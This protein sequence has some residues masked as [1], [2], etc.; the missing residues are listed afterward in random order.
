MGGDPTIGGGPR[1]IIPQNTGNAEGVN[2]NGNDPQIAH[3]DADYDNLVGFLEDA[4]PFMGG[5]DDRGANVAHGNAN[6][7]PGIGEWLSDRGKDIGN[8]FKGI[9]KGIA[10]A[11]KSVRMSVDADYRQLQ[12]DK[13]DARQQ[14]AQLQPQIAQKPDSQQR[15]AMFLTAVG[16]LAS[17]L[18]L[19]YNKVPEDRR[20][21]I[22]DFVAD[23]LKAPDGDPNPGHSANVDDL[24]QGTRQ[25]ITADMQSKIDG[26]G[27]TYDDSLHDFATAILDTFDDYPST[28]MCRDALFK[29]E[30]DSARGDPT[31]FLR[32]NSTSTKFSSIFRT[33][34]VDEGQIALTALNEMKDAAEDHLELAWKT[35]GTVNHKDPSPQQADALKDIV[36]G[37]V[38]GLTAGD[39]NG[40]PIPQELATDLRE[41]ADLILQDP[42]LGD[43][44]KNSMI[45]TLY[46]NDLALRGIIPQI[47][48]GNNQTAQN[49][50]MSAYKTKAALTAMILLNGAPGAGFED[51]GNQMLADL[52]QTEGPR[53]ENFLLDCGMPPQAAIDHNA[54]GQ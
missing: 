5:N 22:Q 23:F 7:G 30:I 9:G 45:R 32:G 24:L 1:P 18:F 13:A 21:S 33:E 29:D 14:Q 40:S 17:E 4:F 52:R 15:D 51:A 2:P 42:D 6:N 26:P 50:P 34:S 49:D 54:I 10:S 41:R 8:F 38:T 27:S 37:L 20:P 16:G 53:I 44:Q 11:F 36:H 28:S 25:N 39:Y 48:T 47:I 19:E 35:D 46:V 31:T 12:A 43:D 3:Q